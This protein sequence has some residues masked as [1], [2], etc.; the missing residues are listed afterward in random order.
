MNNTAQGWRQGKWGRGSGLFQAGQ[1]R[2]HGWKTQDGCICS[3]WSVREK[4]ERGEHS[5]ARWRQVGCSSCIFLSIP[6]T[7]KMCSRFSDECRGNQF[8]ETHVLSIAQR[9]IFSYSQNGCIQRE[10]GCHHCGVI[11]VVSALLKDT[12]LLGYAHMPGLNRFLALLRY[13]VE[14]TYGPVCVRKGKRYRG[15]KI[16]E[17]FPNHYIK[18]EAEIRTSW[19]SGEVIILNTP[20]KMEYLM[21]LT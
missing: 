10:E 13:T 6:D 1:V 17:W 19:D 15:F 5:A 4:A 2:K 9:G 8:A 12:C 14:W 16:L 3:E 20:C 18:T 7:I 11:N 21:R